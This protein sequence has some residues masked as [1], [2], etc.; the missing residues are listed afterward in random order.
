MESEDKEIKVEESVNK[1]ADNT[2]SVDSKLLINALNLIHKDH[3]EVIDT[4]TGLLTTIIH[5]GKVKL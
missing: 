2:I 5:S 1:V 4:Y 3:A